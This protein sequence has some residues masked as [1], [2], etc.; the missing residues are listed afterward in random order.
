MKIVNE[1]GRVFGVINIIDL[2]VLI[3]LVLLIPMVFYWFKLAKN[4]EEVIGKKAGYCRI[5]ARFD[6]IPSE[7]AQAVKEGDYE[8]NRNG[9]VCRKVISVVRD[10]RTKGLDPNNRDIMLLMEVL[11]F[12]FDDGYVMNGGI[13][14]LAGSETYFRT[15]RYIL[16]GILTKVYWQD[17]R[18]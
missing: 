10:E 2:L 3:F 8:K 18:I 4:P 17:I 6:N 12:K 14:L 7:V 13:D 1:K 11:Y 15:T 16:K 5:E 9:N